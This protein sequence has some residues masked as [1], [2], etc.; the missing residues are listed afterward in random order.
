MQI[1]AGWHSGHG[2][3]DPDRQSDGLDVLVV[4]PAFPWVASR[5]TMLYL[6]TRTHSTVLQYVYTRLT[7]LIAALRKFWTDWLPTLR[8]RLQAELSHFSTRVLG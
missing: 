6:A 2:T 3:A 5:A 1:V 7:L 4:K 8:I